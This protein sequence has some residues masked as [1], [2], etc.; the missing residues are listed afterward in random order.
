MTGSGDVTV[1]GNPN[2]REISRTGSGSVSFQD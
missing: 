1:Y 2:N